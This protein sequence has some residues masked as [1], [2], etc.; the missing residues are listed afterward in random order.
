M[1]KP[2]GC[3]SEGYIQNKQSDQK[4]KSKGC[5]YVLESDNADISKKCV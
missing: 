4:R 1:R 5:G 2:G 3:S